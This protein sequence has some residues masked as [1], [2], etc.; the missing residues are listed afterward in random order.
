MVTFPKDSQVVSAKRN[1]FRERFDGAYLLEIT[2][3][4]KCVW[5][6]KKVNFTEASTV[7]YIQHFA[8]FETRISL[9]FSHVYKFSLDFHA[10]HSNG[11]RTVKTLEINI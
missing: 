4:V 10:S 11:K 1:R 9:K 6:R 7:V 2:K 3:N 5:K 8:P